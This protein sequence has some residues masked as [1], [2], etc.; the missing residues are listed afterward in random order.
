MGVHAYGRIYGSEEDMARLKKN[1][2]KKKTGKKA[3]RF[4]I[5]WGGLTALAISTLCTLLWTFIM[6]FWLGQKLVGRDSISEKNITVLNRLDEKAPPDTPRLHLADRS[7]EPAFPPVIAGRDTASLRSE[8]SRSTD[9]NQS[10]EALPTENVMG[11]SHRAPDS[12]VVRPPEKKSANGRAERKKEQGQRIKPV[13]KEP[14]AARKPIRKVVDTHETQREKL[15]V[16]KTYF[17]LQ[18]ASYRDRAKAEKQAVHWRKKGVAAQVSRVSIKKKGI[19]YRVYLGRYV[20][21]QEA[22][23]GAKRLAR[24]EGIRSYVVPIKP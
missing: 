2:V 23:A 16:P 21:V 6:G 18:I 17:V 13:K 10:M 11:D 24:K 19:W 1:S 14:K 8:N 9:D 22:T 7:M 4:Q 15:P 3:I 5:G 20:S 12:M